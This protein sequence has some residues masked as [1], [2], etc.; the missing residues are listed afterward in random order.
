MV[1][2][3]LTSLLFELI[4]SMGDSLKFPQ[5]VLKKKIEKGSSNP[6][7][8]YF[9]ETLWKMSDIVRGSSALSGLL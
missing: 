5:K 3:G 8:D 4:L 2:D 6:V 7:W 9:G 1:L